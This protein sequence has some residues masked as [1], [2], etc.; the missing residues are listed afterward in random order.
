MQT[1]RSKLEN[2][3]VWDAIKGIEPFPFIQPETNTLFVLWHGQHW[4][5]SSLENESVESIAAMIVHIFGEKWQNLLEA[6]GIPM[7][8]SSRRTI[9]ETVDTNENR[10]NERSD[11]AKVAAY[12]SEELLDESGNDSMGTEGV[13]G[14]RIRHLTDSTESLEAAFNNLTR[15]DRLNIVKTAMDDVA[16]FMKLDVY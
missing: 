11:K 3:N 13:E 12:N 4:L 10:T 1:I 7:A 8:A 15:L 9:E 6:Q 2:E 16:N 14:E 5:F